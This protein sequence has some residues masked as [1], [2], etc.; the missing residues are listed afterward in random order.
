MGE[1]RLFSSFTGTFTLIPLIY[2][3]LQHIDFLK[4]GEAKKVLLH[5]S[6][7]SILLVINLFVRSV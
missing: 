4:M 2:C 5:P 6:E 3:N 1:L 7:P